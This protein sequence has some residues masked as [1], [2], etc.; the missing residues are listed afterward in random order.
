MSYY[1]ADKTYFLTSDKSRVVDADSPEAAHLLV[2][3]GGHL[4][5]WVARYYGLVSDETMNGK[6]YQEPPNHKA[7]LFPP[8]N[9]RSKKR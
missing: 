3:I 2:G 4:P 9:K 6:S 5:L 8:E 7:V 1:I